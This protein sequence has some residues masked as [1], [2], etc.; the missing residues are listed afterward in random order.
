MFNLYRASQVLFPGEKLLED[1]KEY[2]FEF[3]REKQAANELLDKWIITKDLPGE[4]SSQTWYLLYII[5]SVAN[6]QHIRLQLIVVIFN[7]IS[8]SN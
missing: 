5:R 2:S 6:I 1:A 7:K 4:V 8:N 3:L